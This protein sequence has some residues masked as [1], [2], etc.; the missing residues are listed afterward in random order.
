[1][2]RGGVDFY[3]LGPGQFPNMK[4]KERKVIT[5]E[6]ETK[7]DEQDNTQEDYNA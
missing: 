4:Q 7:V 5:K 2:P 1:M 3:F 6:K